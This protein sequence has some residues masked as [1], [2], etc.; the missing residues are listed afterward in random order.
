MKYAFNPISRVKKK[1]FY[2]SNRRAKRTC[3]QFQSHPSMQAI[4]KQQQTPKLTGSARTALQTIV[5]LHEVRLL[6]L[7]TLSLTDCE[8]ECLGLA[9]DLE[10][11]RGNE[12]PVIEV[13]RRERLTT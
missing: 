3:I 9:A 11:I 5:V 4:E 12:L 6:D 2:D 8:H 13:V 7:K 10:R 1:I